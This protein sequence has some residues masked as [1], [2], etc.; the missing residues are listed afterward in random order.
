MVERALEL[1]SIYDAVSVIVERFKHLSP[2]LWQ[3][4]EEKN[5]NISVRDTIP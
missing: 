1:S 3:W 5:I 4:S 2:F